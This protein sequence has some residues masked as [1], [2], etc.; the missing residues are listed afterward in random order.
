MEL[1]ASL[2]ELCCHEINQS[3]THTHTHTHT[4]HA[5]A[6]AYSKGPCDSDAATHN[7]LLQD[8][9]V[10]LS[11]DTYVTSYKIITLLQL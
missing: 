2:E 6:H 8:H 10:S 5:H 1:L 3:V 11:H 9:S 7:P 4:Y